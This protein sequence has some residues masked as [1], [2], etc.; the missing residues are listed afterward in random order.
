M[1]DGLAL[2]YYRF[3]R[4]PTSIASRYYVACLVFL[5]LLVIADV[6]PSIISRSINLEFISMI[7]TLHI[8]SIAMLATSMKVMVR[9]M[10][11]RQIV[12]AMVITTGFGIPLEFISSYI[13]LYGISYAVTPLIGT[14]AFVHLAGLVNGIVYT[15]V[16]PL[17]IETIFSYVN[18]ENLKLLL[19]RYSL[20][21]LMQLASLTVIRSLKRRRG[22]DVLRIANAWLKFM[23]SGD[24]SDLE[25]ALDDIG[26]EFDAQTKVL[27]FDRGSDVIALVTPT[28]H[29]GPYRTIGSTLLPYDIESALEGRGFKV[30]V[31]HG[32]G[33]H[34]LDLTKRSYGT[35]LASELSL[36]LSKD[37]RDLSTEFAYE[38]FRVFNGFREAMVLQTDTTAM[39][40]ITPV[41]V[42]GDDMPYEL[43]PIA[44]DVARLYGFRD[45]V[46]VDAH[47]VEGKRDINVSSF[48]SL[49]KAG[50]S[51]RSNICKELL[52]GYGE[53]RI[54][55][56]VRGVCRNKVKALTI[57]C[58]GNLYSIVY[59]YGNNAK[60]GVRENLRKMILEKGYKDA[61]IVTLDDHS[62]AGI[63]FDV[64]YHSIDISNALIESAKRAL[65]SSLND[66]KPAS[67]KYTKYVFKVRVAGN[68]IFE[69]LDVAT[70]IGSSIL[71]YLKISL[72]MLYSL[73]LV[74]TV[75]IFL[76]G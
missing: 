69:L 21:A 60:V 39:L 22:Y 32:A 76:H 27:L 53:S 18:R 43:Q 48:N 33:S 30:F 65:E 11:L 36:R 55:D 6:Y 16:V 34:E 72:P 3:L 5:A 26:V 54:R 44:E 8:V 38:P 20:A 40:I 45:A 62:C 13:R 58:N 23:L 29:F 73:W 71:R 10:K 31:F 57:K 4:I 42:G 63:T 52:V 24:G 46:I 66:L 50:I 61:E 56:Y 74:A 35:A 59:L 41:A 12:N 25:E 19:L 49:I 47:N 64:P 70:D 15:T 9:Y 2:R 17:A 37:C 1:L 67:C 7:I 68:K 28:I 51:K 14:I 75:L